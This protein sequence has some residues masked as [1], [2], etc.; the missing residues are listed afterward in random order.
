MKA[1]SVVRK[2]NILR[3]EVTLHNNIKSQLDET[4]THFIDNYNQLN[5]FRAIISS[6]LRST[7]LCLQLVV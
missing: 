7:R 5:M 2:I 6:I 3:A 1:H 4:I